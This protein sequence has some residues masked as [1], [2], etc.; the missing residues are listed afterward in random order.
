MSSN[1]GGGFNGISPKQ[2][3]TNYKSSEGVMMRRVLVKSWNTPYARG[4]VNGRSRVVTPFR[5]INNSGDFLGR[6]Q[7]SCGG[8]NP[9]NATRPGYAIRIR[10]MFQNCDTSGVPASSTNVKY[11]PDSSDYTTFKK[12]QAINR[13]Y[14]DKTFGGDDHHGSYTAYMRVSRF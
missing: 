14:N 13:N 5:A 2:T 8:P 1:L 10:N 9:T 11:V 7:Y 4:V 3:I 12:Q 6:V